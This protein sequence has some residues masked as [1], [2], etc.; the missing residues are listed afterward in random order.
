MA[1]R[2]EADFELVARLVA[3]DLS[4]EEVFGRLKE[5]VPEQEYAVLFL[6]QA[7]RME[8][9]ITLVTMGAP[10]TVCLGYVQHWH[11]DRVRE[12]TRATMQFWVSRYL[13]GPSVW[14]STRAKYQADMRGGSHA[15]ELTVEEW[16]AALG[17]GIL[18]R[19]LAQDYSW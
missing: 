8:D 1:H 19:K 7:G 4:A 9:A 13:A 14:E 15:D 12:F 10:A 5:R 2:T 6:A 16:L 18:V 11:G 3:S 17:Y